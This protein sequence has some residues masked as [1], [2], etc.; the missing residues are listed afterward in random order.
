MDSTDNSAKANPL[1]FKGKAVLVTGGGKGIGRGISE[2]F[3]AAGADVLIDS[4]SAD[5]LSELRSL[6]PIDVVYDAVGATC[7]RTHW[8]R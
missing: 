5:L 6:G 2:R 4:E 7:R 8:A 1:D 3:L